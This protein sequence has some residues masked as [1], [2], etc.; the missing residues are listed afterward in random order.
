MMLQ[1]AAIPAADEQ[2]QLLLTVVAA[3]EYI[4]VLVLQLPIDILLCKEHTAANTIT[5]GAHAGAD[6]QALLQSGMNGSY[7]HSASVPRP[8]YATLLVSVHCQARGQVCLGLQEV[9]LS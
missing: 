2:Q 5:P 8:M 7:H 3:D 1:V 6:C 9:Q 4:T